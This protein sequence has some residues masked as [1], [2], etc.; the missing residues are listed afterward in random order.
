MAGIK[1]ELSYLMLGQQGGENRIKIL[2]HLKERS[3]NLNQLSN[4][5]DL[6]YR[7]IKH[8][9]DVLEDHDLIESSGEG[10]GEVYF[11]SSKLEDDYE[12][13]EEMKSK[14][15]TVFKSPK[16]YEK[17]VEQ[18]HEGIIVLDENKDI[19]F[20]NKS[21]QKITRY[22]DEDLIGKNIEELVESNINQ[23][24]EQVL[25]KDEFFEETIKIKTKSEETKTV[26]ITMD[27]FHF[28]GEEH[29]GFS[30][31]MRDV[32]KER[33]QKEILD[34]LM[35]HSE[36]IM[37]YLDP[38]FDLVYVNSAYAEKTDH[39]PGELIG[40][41]HFDLFPNEEYIDIFERVIE[42]KKTVSIKDKPLLYLD[43]SEKED[44]HWTLEPVTDSGEEI[45]GLVLS[46]C[47]HP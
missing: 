28:D 44:I 14:L 25:T 20:L 19:I 8:H 32:T 27:H 33:K 13:L 43:A 23:S 31:L 3:Y 7:T 5:L 4:K 38:N 16:V 42:E 36:V 24:L 26:V 9:I 39:S 2:E 37:A 18:T 30:L 17:V 46:L 47:E 35:D 6:N 34:A 22:E 11:L 45:Q 1:R 29:K 15:Q 40:K 21:A 41:N 12:M 10:Y